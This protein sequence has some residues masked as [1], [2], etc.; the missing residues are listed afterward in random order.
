MDAATESCTKNGHIFVNHVVLDR[1]YNKTE[2][3]EYHMKVVADKQL[4][5]PPQV[6]HQLPLH[7]SRP[8]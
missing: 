1:L 2:I 5:G 3:R 4:T 7:H 6:R 8:W